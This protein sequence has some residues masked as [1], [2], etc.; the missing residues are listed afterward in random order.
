LG[1][2]PLRSRA[3]ARLL[4]PERRAPDR[5]ASLRGCRRLWLPRDSRDDVSVAGGLDM[6]GASSIR[7]SLT[8]GMVRCLPSANR[9]TSYRSRG[10]AGLRPFSRCP[11]RPN[12]HSNVQRSCGGRPRLVAGAGRPPTS[13]A[14][15]TGAKVAFLPDQQSAVTLLRFVSPPHIGDARRHTVPIAVVRL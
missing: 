2:S 12:V 15:R 1:R 6:V 8:A 13:R 10:A 14:G 7:S 3:N 11:R 4:P 5:T 9:D